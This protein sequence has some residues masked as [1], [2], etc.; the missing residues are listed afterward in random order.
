MPLRH[1][2]LKKKKAE[3]KTTRHPRTGGHPLLLPLIIWILVRLPPL[4]V[5]RV[6]TIHPPQVGAEKL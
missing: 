3:L 6:L 5:A 2:T 1:E 4:R